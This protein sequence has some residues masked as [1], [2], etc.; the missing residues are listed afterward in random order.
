MNNGEEAYW[1][2]LEAAEGDKHL[3]AMEAAHEAAML[4]A[5]QAE[6]ERAEE[7]AWWERY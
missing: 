7:E 1:A 6:H 2:A 4:A 5:Q 3:A